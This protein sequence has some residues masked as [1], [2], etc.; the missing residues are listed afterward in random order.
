MF[1]FVLLK[2]LFCCVFVFIF[3]SL[4]MGGFVYFGGAIAGHRTAA[5]TCA[6]LR[7]MTFRALFKSGAFLMLE[8]QQTPPAAQPSAGGTLKVP[9]IYGPNDLTK[10]FGPVR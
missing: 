3:L 4:L 7:S 2:N 10:S 1:I 9:F 6:V 5:M 8:P